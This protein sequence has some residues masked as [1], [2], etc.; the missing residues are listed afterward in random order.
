MPN[1]LLRTSLRTPHL[2]AVHLSGRYQGS[3]TA[4]MTDLA[5]KGPKNLTEK[6]LLRAYLN[7]SKSTLLT[8]LPRKGILNLWRHY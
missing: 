5:S 6:Q 4:R 2:F 3:C 8:D 7:I 1:M